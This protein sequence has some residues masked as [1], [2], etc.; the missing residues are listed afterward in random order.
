MRKKKSLVVYGYSGYAGNI[1][2]FD[3]WISRAYKTKRYAEQ[4]YGTAHVRKV[5]ITI[6]EL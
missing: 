4:D 3:Y 6:E 1:K 2:H 5:R